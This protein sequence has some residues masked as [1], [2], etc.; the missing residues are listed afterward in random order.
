M[1]YFAQKQHRQKISFIS[2]LNNLVL[3]TPEPHS[4][5]CTMYICTICLQFA[6][7]LSLGEYRIGRGQRF[8]Y[9]RLYLVHPPPPPTHVFPSQLSRYIHCPYLFLSPT[10]LCVWRCTVCSVSV[11]S[12]LFNHFWQ[13]IFILEF[14]Y[15]LVW[16]FWRSIWK[17]DE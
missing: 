3:K 4:F 14:F 13:G 9:S 17:S 1:A 8:F 5:Q 7:T 6:S 15:I 2:L 12:L 16:I 10:S 11:S